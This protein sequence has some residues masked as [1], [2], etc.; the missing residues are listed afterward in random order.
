MPFILGGTLAG[1]L[2]GRLRD[3]GI[4]NKFLNDL[5]KEVQPGTSALIIYG[6]SDEQRRKQVVQRLAGFNPKIL[7]SSLPDE[8]EQAFNEAMAASQKAAASG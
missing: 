1:K 8:L 3:D 2:I 4:T 7:E 6:R 5:S